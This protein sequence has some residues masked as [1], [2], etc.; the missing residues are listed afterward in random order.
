[1]SRFLRC[2]SSA[3]LVAVLLCSGCSMTP[4]MPTPKAE[5]DLP[6]AYAP[7]PGDT[8]LPAAAT[9]TSAYD[10]QRWW[11]AF[12]DSTLTTLV[13]TAIASNLDLEVAQAR[14]EEL[15]AQF[16]IARAP[17]F[18]SVNANGE[19][20]YQSQPASAG[21][22]GEFG[23]DGSGGGSSRGG[24]RSITPD[25]F[26]FSTY[27]ASLG[28]SYEL[29]FWGRVRDQR[30]AA[31]SQYFA[32]A[33]DLQT[34]RI[35]VT[36][37]TISTYFEVASLQRQ[38][39]LGRRTVDLLE[40]RLA[41]TEDRYGRGLASS[42]Q[43]FTVQQNLGAAQA[44][45]PQLEDQLYDAR[46]RL[47]TLLG[48]FAGTASDVL[49][50]SLAPSVDLSPVPAGLP[51]DLLMQ[52]PDV[53]AEALR[54]EA[55]RRQVGV[56]RAERLPSLS[57]TGTGGTQSSALESL[58]DLD[59]RFANFAA[60]L[61]APLF[62]GG[63][64]QANTNAAEARYKQQA[65]RYENTVLTAFREVKAALVAYDRQR[66]RLNRGQEQVASARASFQ[67]QRDRYERGVGTVLSLLDAERGLVQAQT[68][69]A[70]ARTAAVNARLALHRALGG[71]WTDTDSVKDPRLFR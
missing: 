49:P 2:L 53:R 62:Q 26:S 66:E 19:A 24:S 34:A 22:G 15:A 9:D 44:E 46:S 58:V 50:D 5:Q 21:I 14:V 25:R 33:A 55:A 3:L 38:V 1:M 57:L 28:L 36:S 42:F 68:R 52:R 32:T 61:T 23:G 11:T 48:R 63:R 70:A 4:S 16:R 29:D 67:T 59:Q 51:A 6:D 64:L 37:Q 39:A 17:L 69:L 27:T 7:A 45:Q 31:L 40:Q 20:R 35:S 47:T 30:K 12:G 13:D 65:A 60:Q 18:P 41:V 56:A 8:L 54:L 71:S 43:L 10:P